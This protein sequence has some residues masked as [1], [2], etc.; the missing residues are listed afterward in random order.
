MV[1]SETTEERLFTGHTGR[2]FLLIT[3]INLSL[4]LT[5]RL[6]PPLLPAILDDLAISAFLG[7]AA[8]T[9]LRV[10]RASMEY[11][12]GRFSDQLTRT[13]VL[14]V[15]LGFIILGVLAL[16]LS[17]T[18]AIFLVG[19][20][21]FGMGLGLNVPAS[22]TLISDLFTE[23]R[24]QAFGF[25]I[26]GGDIAGILAA[27]TAIVIVSIATWRAAF[28]PLAIVLLPL[29][30]ALYVLS[31]ERVH[32]ERADF[33]LRKTVVRLF[34]NP[35][36]RWLMAVYAL[37][38]LASSGVT[39][40]LPTFLIEIHGVSFAI[41]SSA[42][43]L[44][45][46]VGL[47]SRPTS[48]FV[49]DRIP[50]PIVA[51]GSLLLASAG[52]VILILAPGTVIA[53]LAVL[54]FAFGQKGLPPALQAYLMDRFPEESM[55]GDFGAFRAVYKVIGSLGPAYTGFVANTLGFLP[56]FTSLIVFFLTG[57]L[58][59]LFFSLRGWPTPS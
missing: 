50:R 10:A 16:S 21:I 38:N 54:V 27:G 33:G 19:V 6:L 59:L 53:I 3:F 42:F 23:K 24:G 51:G 18:Y 12:G 22:R 57:G 30:L 36:M 1:Y 43:A 47:V 14:L 39:A 26:M 48:G 49:S 13:T 29:P 17:T 45:F 37:F 35:S 46:V 28:L 31:R 9:L 55:G 34:G 56:A 2:L 40:F 44:L 20:V 52:L 5:Q 32:F 7:G 8:L 41:A 4:Q 11:P 25:N 15:S 58:I